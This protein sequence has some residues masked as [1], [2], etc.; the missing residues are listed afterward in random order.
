MTACDIQPS[1]CQNGGQCVSSNRNQYFCKCPIGYTG[2]NCEQI[3]G[4]PEVAAP[5]TGS[6]PEIVNDQPDQIVLG[7]V[8]G[9]AIVLVVIGLL[10]GG[11]ICWIRSRTSHL[12]YPES[13]ADQ[14]METEQCLDPEQLSVLTSVQPGTS[15]RTKVYFEENSKNSGNSTK[16]SKK[17]SKET[18]NRTSLEL[19][20]AEPP[21]Y[22]EVL[23]DRKKDSRDDSQIIIA[24]L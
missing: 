17:S 6:E 23:I 12:K 9:V 8:I 7:I 20:N 13:P 22:E 10:I 18:E 15:A 1:K 21:S 4:E 19:E 5:I 11:F 24:R 3:V 16:N 2:Y 14:I